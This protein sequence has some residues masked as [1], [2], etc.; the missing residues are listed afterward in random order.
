MSRKVAREILYQLV[1]EYS[2]LKEINRDTL[3]IMLIGAELSED[4][5]VYINDG[6]SIVSEGYENFVS[7]IEKLIIDFKI[8]RIHRADLTAMIVA[9]YEIEACPE[10]PEAVS[11]NEAVYLV[12]KFSTDKSYSY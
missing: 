4:D 12:K 5:K 6:Y 10:I 7:E 2:F 9:L 1:F 8:E 11:V 3:E